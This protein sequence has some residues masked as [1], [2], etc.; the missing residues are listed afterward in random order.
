M[1]NKLVGFFISATLLFF[2]GPTKEDDNNKKGGPMQPEE[3]LMARVELLSVPLGREPHNLTYEISDVGPPTDLVP[4]PV[5]FDPKGGLLLVNPSSP[6]RPEPTLMRI[7]KDSRTLYE[8]SLAREELRAIS[9]PFQVL[10]LFLG[11]D[12]TVTLLFGGKYSPDDNRYHEYSL[13]QF[14]GG[15]RTLGFTTLPEFED[16]SPIYRGSDGHLWVCTREALGESWAVYN[17]SGLLQRRI[18]GGNRAV[19]LP[20]NRLLI[21]VEDSSP[22]LCDGEGNRYPVGLCGTL[23]P[24]GMVVPGTGDFFGLVAYSEPAWQKDSSGNMVR[25]QSVQV[26]FFDR[27]SQTLFLSPIQSLPPDM[28]GP[29]GK[30]G[31]F[32]IYDQ[33]MMSFDSEGNLYL[34]G[35]YGPREPVL[36]V[37][38]MT[39]KPDALKWFRK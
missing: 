6:L 35:R 32:E 36:K 17:P 18:E 21:L 37:F 25:T 5:M 4:G 22:V 27:Q 8:I 16:G 3:V 1:K 31:N 19:L 23:A 34:V 15:G 13:A 2:S 30:P 10:C 39:L 11:T 14:D 26:G 7:G 20:K 29:E 12:D 38:R 9:K 24:G 33:R 28:V